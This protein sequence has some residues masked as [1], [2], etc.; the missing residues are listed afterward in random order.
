MSS[1]G[2]GGNG[3][4]GPTVLGLI[5]KKGGKDNTTTTKRYSKPQKKPQNLRLFA[6]L[7]ADGDLLLALYGAVKV[8]YYRLLPYRHRFFPKVAKSWQK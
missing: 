1:Q 4:W 8:N 7:L 6:C 5:A 2:G 3:P